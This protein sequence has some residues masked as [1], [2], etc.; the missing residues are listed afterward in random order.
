MCN[1]LGGRRLAMF[2]LALA[3]PVLLAP[4]RA[5]EHLPTGKFSGFQLRDY[6]GKE[7]TAEQFR[8]QKV[9][10]L[11]FLGT[12]CPL[13]KLYAPRLAALNKEYAPRGVAFVG[14]SSNQQDSVTELGAF[15][16]QQGIEFPILKDLNNVLAD[17]LG[18]QRTPEAFVLDAERNVR[19]RGRI[20]DQYG[21][22]TEGRIGY[23]RKEPSRRDLAQAID[24]LLDGKEVSVASTEAPGCLIGR[25]RA[26]QAGSSVTYS[27]KIAAIFNQNC[28]FCHRPGQIG[29]FSL[30]S[31][32]DAAGWAEMIGEVVEMRRMPPWH[33][34]PAVGHWSNDARLSDEDREAVLT[35]VKNGAPA[36]DLNEVPAPPQFTEGWQ[37]SEPDQVIWMDDEPYTVPA[38][39][40]VDY[41]RFLIDPGWTE[42]KWIA[43]IE[44]RVGNPSVVHHI[45]IYLVPPKNR[46]VK[47][48]AGRL[49]ND[50]LAAYAPGLRQERLP[51]G[52][53]RFCPAGSQ[54]IFEMH[55]TPNGIEQ[56]DRSYLGIKFADPKQVRKEV[57]VKNAGNFTFEIPPGDPNYQVEST[58][59]FREDSE[60]V[61]VSP[62]MHVRGKDFFYELVYPDGK[63]EPI[64]NVPLYDFGWQTTYM[65]PQPKLVPKGTEMH[66]V[67]HF[68]NSPENLNNPDPTA[69][70]RWGEQTFEEMMFGWFEMAP[71]DQDLTKPAPPPIS[72][73]KQFEKLAAAGA[74]KVDD[75]LLQVAARC[76]VDEENFKFGAFYLA[77]FVPQ[78]DRVCITYVE[79]GKLRARVVEELG[80]LKTTL[81][82]RGTV[83]DAKGQ[84]LADCLAS[85]DV[86]VFND[87]SQAA[88]SV[89]QRMSSKGM[90]SSMHVPVVLDGVPCTVNFWST[91][92][93]A[94]PAAAVSFLSEFARAIE[95]ANTEPAN[96]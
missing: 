73:V 53:A 61:S 45:V 89:M 78:L 1:V 42:D 55:Y 27:N 3:V 87:L 13:A 57:A 37:I 52:Y 85:Q 16:R 15:A 43:E 64:L 18:A 68:D 9:L 46:G 5:A 39:G 6:R 67:A 4:A 70:V 47:G 65:F 77:D 56:Q 66:C 40:V 72:R 19:Y 8:D 17:T 88:G 59:T 79:D 24:E 63:R 29:P 22:S 28:V 51:E 10:V 96:K 21:F 76:L 90:S 49:R 80:D 41:Q 34:D 58:F 69:K 86:T 26:P 60:L 82:S 62:H 32:E 54:L 11:V 7:F 12:E 23:Q 14:I 31:Y 44:P 75:Q 20:D 92:P 81:R 35:W 36:G 95:K 83:V 50:W 93:A 94:F 33:A 91:E 74:L 71:A 84:A 48:A 25:V 2:S 30:T 38:E